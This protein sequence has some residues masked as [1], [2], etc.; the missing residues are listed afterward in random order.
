[1]TRNARLIRSP[2]WS[3]VFGI[4]CVARVRETVARIEPAAVVSVRPLSE[5]LRRALELPR[6][7]ASIAGAIALLGVILSGVGVFGVFAYAVA[8]RTR[9]IG[10]RMAL[11]PSGAH[12]RRLLFRQTA[13]PLAGGLVVGLAGAL[14]AAP[15]LRAYLLGISPHDPLAFLAAAIVLSVA[16]LLATLHPARRAVRVDPAVTLRHE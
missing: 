6:L 1:L 8:D 14:L 11:G 16:A 5:N 2:A 7:G 9:E 3:S 4:A 10:I 13:T 15:L 12:V